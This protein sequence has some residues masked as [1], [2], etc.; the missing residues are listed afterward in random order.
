MTNATSP[1]N[2]SR[3]TA[4]IF[5]MALLSSAACAGSSAAPESAVASEGAASEGRE[6]TTDVKLSFDVFTG[7]ESGFLA[8]S[9]LIMG[10]RDAILIDAQFTLGNGKK[11]A[12]WIASKDRDLKAIYI[13]HAHPDHYFG[14]EEVLARFPNTPVYATSDVIAHMRQIEAG[15]LAYWGPIYK[16][17]LTIAPV[18]PTPLSTPYLELEG[19]RLD[20]VEIAQGDTDPTTIVHAASLGLIVAGDVTYQGVHAW[21]AETP[22]QALRD[23]WLS[24]L[25]DLAALRPRHVVAGHRASSADYSIASI[26]ETRSYI[27]DFAR[28]RSEN[29]EAASFLA[30]MTELHA[31]KKLPIILQIAAEAT[32]K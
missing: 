11:L 9:T 13:T 4:A 20:L 15:K 3:R 1:R 22:T 26:A 24:G 19:N 29:Q 17:D 2:Q 25:D 12:T 32:Y 31:E 5:A 28:L 10:E 30:A 8:S 7:D 16:D 6:E 27:Q 21:L 14:A 18:N 23:G